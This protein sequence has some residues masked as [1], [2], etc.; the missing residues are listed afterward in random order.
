MLSTWG[1][2]GRGG[3]VVLM[4]WS[5]HNVSLCCGIASE[6][7]RG[8]GLHRKCGQATDHHGPT[9]QV[10]LPDY[11]FIFLISTDVER[12]HCRTHNPQILQNKKHR[13]LC[14]KTRYSPFYSTYCQ[15]FGLGFRRVMP[16]VANLDHY[17]GFSGI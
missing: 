6:G 16:V 15:Q 2:L 12:Q 5:C 9:D 7:Q 3:G 10:N 4:D 17:V 8:Q 11:V 14:N 13:K 1:C